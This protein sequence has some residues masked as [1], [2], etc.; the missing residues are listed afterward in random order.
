M[1]V[2]ELGVSELGVRGDPSH[3]DDQADRKGRWTAAIVSAVLVAILLA[4]LGA[5][6]RALG[7]FE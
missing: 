7:V 2:L 4:I 1:V 3:F 5:L 6:A